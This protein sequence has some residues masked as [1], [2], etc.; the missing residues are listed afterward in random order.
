LID[1]LQEEFLDKIEEVLQS[2]D[3]LTFDGNTV[4]EVLMIEMPQGCWSTLCTVQRRME[5]EEMSGL[6]QQ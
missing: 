3:E 4:I 1:N 6:D 5:F 2:Q